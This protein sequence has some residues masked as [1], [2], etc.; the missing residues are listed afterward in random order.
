[1]LYPQSYTGVIPVAGFEPASTRV[2]C[3][4]TLVFTTGRRYCS[5]NLVLLNLAGER[6]IR[7]ETDSSRYLALR[8]YAPVPGTS[9]PRQ[10]SL[11]C[12]V[13]GRSNSALSPPAKLHAMRTHLRTR[14]EL[15]FAAPSTQSHSSRTRVSAP[16]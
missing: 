3:E 2:G 1:V 9:A 7:V 15:A 12:F 10:G 5:F 6:S 4:V 13:I 16:H 8:G 11:P 14:G